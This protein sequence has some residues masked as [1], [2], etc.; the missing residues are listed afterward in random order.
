MLTVEEFHYYSCATYLR[1]NMHYN[2]Y[3]DT[4]T[5]QLFLFK[6]RKIR[7]KIRDRLHAHMAHS[8]LQLSFT[9]SSLMKI[10]CREVACRIPMLLFQ[11]QNGIN[12]MF[13]SSSAEIPTLLFIQPMT[14]SMMMMMM[15]DQPQ[16]T[17]R[18]KKF[19]QC[20]NAIYP[21]LHISH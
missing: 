5:R 21:S 1:N 4:Y 16:P 14:L 8:T 10:Y 3:R 9:L 7:L 19:Y 2:R 12:G 18:P 15:M 13:T 17:E 6:K 11:A 20:Q